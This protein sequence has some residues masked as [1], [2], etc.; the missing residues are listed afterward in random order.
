[1]NI[2]PS[3][4][5]RLF[6][7]GTHN[8]TYNRQISPRLPRSSP[9]IEV[10]IPDKVTRQHAPIPVSHVKVDVNTVLHHTILYY[11]MLR[12]GTIRYDMVWYGMYTTNVKRPRTWR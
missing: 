1:M 4:V 3:R 9:D 12:Y 5:K 11:D 6:I 7:T 8:H 2:N 10:D